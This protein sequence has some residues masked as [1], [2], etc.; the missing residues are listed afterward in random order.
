[1][2]SNPGNTTS[3]FFTTQVQY[4]SKSRN[5]SGARRGSADNENEWKIEKLKKKE[6]LVRR[7]E[8]A[9]HLSEQI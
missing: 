9:K 3:R 8:L 6:F 2:K 4:I 1:M 5:S 7:M